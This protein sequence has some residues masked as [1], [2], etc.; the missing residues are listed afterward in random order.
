LADSGEQA[1]LR[2]NLGLP[3][4]ERPATRIQPPTRFLHDEARVGAEVALPETN[5]NIEYAHR[6]HEQAHE[7]H[8]SPSDR[9]HELVAIAEALLLAIVAIATA[10]SGYQAAKW[11]ALSAKQYGMSSST[12]VLS[13]EKATLAGQEH[14]YDTTTFNGWMFAKTNNNEAL[15]SFYVRRFRP[16]YRT[17]FEAWIKLDP[18]HNPDAPAGPSYMPEYKDANAE[19]ARQLMQKAKTYFEQGVDT[20][21]TGDQ[22]VKVTVFLATVLLLTALSQRFKLLGPRIA[23]VGIALLL[24]IMSTVLLVQLPRA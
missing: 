11:D 13:Q 6:I 15:Q 9:R 22:Y 4:L 14:L 21:E 2:A 23:V 18:F 12:I 19:E 8:P 16:E 10:W 1:L 20:R 24:L 7:H 5:S 17:A 3:C